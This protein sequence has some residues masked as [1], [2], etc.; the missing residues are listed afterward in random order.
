[1]E[2]SKRQVGY[3]VAAVFVIYGLVFKYPIPC[4]A[5]DEGGFFH[6]CISGT[7]AGSASCS[8]H[9]LAEKRFTQATG[10][11]EDAGEVLGEIW[12]FTSEGL[13]DVIKD[14]IVIMRDQIL[15]LKN[16]VFEKINQV[17]TFLREKISLFIGKT[18]DIATDA[19]NKYLKKVIDAMI[20][21]VTRNIV[22]PMLTIIDKI[23]DFREMVWNNLKA[24]VQKVSD[25]NILGF[26]TSIVDV[27]KKIPE[28]LDS[29]KHGVVD[30]INRVK[31][32]LINGI[33]TAINNSAELVENVVGGVSNM[34]EQVVDGTEGVV[35]GS[36]S[37]IND[38]INNIEGTANTVTNSID[39]MIN[40]TIV[41]VA[42]TITGGIRSARDF[43]FLGKNWLS[44]LPNPSDMEEVDIKDLDIPSVPKVDFPTIDFAIDIPEVDFDVP[45]LNA[46]DL[47][48]GNIPGFGFISDKIN[49]LVES[50][51][52]IFDNAMDPVYSAIAT[53]TVLVGNTVSAVKTFYTNYL[54]WDAIKTRAK[55]LYEQGKDGISQLKDFIIDD[56]L[57]AFIDILIGFKDVLLDFI[58]DVAEKAWVFLKKVGVTINNMF[59]QAMKVVTKVSKIVLKATWGAFTFVL[60]RTIDKFTSWIP[61][62]LS[63]RVLLVLVTIVYMLLGG[64]L[65]N[66]LDI[67]R[68]GGSVTTASLMALS[69][70]D[71]MVTDLVRKALPNLGI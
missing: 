12:T 33:E 22:N 29:L 10:I 63:F 32:G 48:I 8:A 6:R 55:N 4:F 19:Y 13:P 27:F 24:A 34:T 26:T 3:A 70:L 46:D 2:N 15:N 69:A 51:R 57:P 11:F 68:L 9:A 61:I 56:L 35:N 28:A 52:N 37:F 71:T 60:G 1:M 47:S 64:F 44:F 42:N 31:N 7:G 30:M 25:L 59:A 18:V 50:M 65:K 67:V 62:P 14:F 40:K 38:R 23:I 16:R 49:S 39:N 54:A 53:V 43:K 20:V 17:I 58:G 36:V 45:D 21:F 41:P 5:C 66:F